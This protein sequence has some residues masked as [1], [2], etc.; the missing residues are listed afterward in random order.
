MAELTYESAFPGRFLKAAIF[1]GKQVT[2][3]IE[4]VFLEDL[5]GEKGIEKKLI[6]A[7]VGKNMQLVCN[8]TN[9]VCLKE[10]FSNKIKSWVGK[11][12][13]FYPT[14]TQFGPKKVDAIRI[15]GSPDIN[16]D[17]EVAARIGRKNFKA[18][19]K[20]VGARTP[21]KVVDEA[22]RKALAP[23]P[24][25]DAFISDADIPESF[26]AGDAKED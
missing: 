7:F 8:K 11:R 10:M 13:T 12:V 17:I 6:M 16:E 4:N 9:A 2:L 20:R 1:D 15:F 26:T 5:E 14:I 18:T 21:A 3:T 24:M 19:M 23:D 22:T 25:D